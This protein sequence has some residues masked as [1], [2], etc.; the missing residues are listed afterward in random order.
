MARDGVFYE[1]DWANVC[2]E[3]CTAS[4]LASENCYYPWWGMKLHIKSGQNT[5]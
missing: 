4:A 2:Y 5:N 1:K 3:T